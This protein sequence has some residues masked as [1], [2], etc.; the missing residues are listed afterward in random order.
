MTKHSTMSR[1]PAVKGFLGC[2]LVDWNTKICAV[3]FLPGCN[4]NCGF[5]H[6]RAL[7][8]EPD[9][10]PDY[11]FHEIESCLQKSKW[12]IDAVTI[13]GGE[14]TIHGKALWSLLAVL[15]V[16]GY[17]VKLDTNG[18]NPRMLESLISSGLVT[19]VY[20]D[21]KSSRWPLGKYQE[22]VGVSQENLVSLLVNASI[23]LLNQWDGEVLFRTTRLPWMADEDIEEIKQWC[24]SKHPHKV[25]EYREPK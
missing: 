24:G 22:V 23:R 20:L 2:S 21:V 14:P 5:C 7:A 6:N 9:S 25:Q 18:S 16:E 3:I 11:P 8:Q 1:L 19:A 17:E 15:H 4:W 10:I 13:T 12:A